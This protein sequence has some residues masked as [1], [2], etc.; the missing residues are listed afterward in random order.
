M[1]YL[2]DKNILIIL[3]IYIL[4]TIN[5]TINNLPLYTNVI[6]PIFW[7]CML[8]YLIW[9][10]KKDYIR[11]NSNKKYFKFMIII[12][13][14]HIVIYFYMGFIIGFS[15]SPYNH[16]I[17]SALKNIIIEIFPIIGIEITRNIVVIS[18]KT[19]KAI[20]ILITILL[21][22][23]EINYNILTTLYSN[24]QEIFKYICGTLLPLTVCNF[25]Y[26]YLTFKGSYLITL[27]YRILINLF[28]LLS[29]ILTNT[30]WFITGTTGILSPAIIYSIFRYKDEKENGEKLEKRITIFTKI[31]Y[32]L[33]FCFC[34][35]LISFMLGIFKYEPITILSNSMVPKFARG[36][37]VIYKKLNKNELQKIPRNSIIVYQKD[38]QNIVHR[39]VDRIKENETIK[40]KT[41]G[42]SNNTADRNLVGADQIK[43]IYIIHIKY[44]GFPSV[45]LYEYFIQGNAKVGRIL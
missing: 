26:T 15:K 23:V 2:R 35:T 1:K 25:L 12:S 27:T 40:Y 32:I 44:I 30:D 36:D 6:N 39:I 11:F 4:I 20:K 31:S 7:G 41:K 18:N 14:I 28:I 45:W 38:G 29:P 9:K 43:G 5:L 37:V 19:N 17:I 10:I 24:K 3:I 33:T 8:V 42:D 16:E 21:I 34:I 22:L 13:F